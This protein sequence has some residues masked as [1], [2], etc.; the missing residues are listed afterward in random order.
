METAAAL[1]GGGH[2]LAD[3]KTFLKYLLI[4]SLV[5]FP[6]AYVFEFK[7]WSLKEVYF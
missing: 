5:F 4:F 7:R 2:L 1:E 6:L 3:F